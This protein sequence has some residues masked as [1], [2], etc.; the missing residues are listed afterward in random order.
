MKALA[1]QIA[2]VYADARAIGSLVC[3]PDTGRSTEWDD[4]GAGKTEPAD[5]WAKFWATQESATGKTREQ[6]MR[7]LERVLGRRPYEAELEEAIRRVFG[8]K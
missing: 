1:D 4:G 8:K 5:W 7:D 3:D 2:A 6:L